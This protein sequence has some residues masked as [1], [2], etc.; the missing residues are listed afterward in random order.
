MYYIEVYI[1]L[2]YSIF[3]EFLMVKAGDYV[4]IRPEEGSFCSSNYYKDFWIGKVISCVGG[5]RNPR[6]WTLFQ[7]LNIDNGEISIVNADTIAT[8]I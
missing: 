2:D 7:V 5:A 6:A 8:I 3:P 4:L 1:I